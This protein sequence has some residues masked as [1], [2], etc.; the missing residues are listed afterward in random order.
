MVRFYAEMLP[1]TLER[2]VDECARIGGAERGEAGLLAWAQQH[3]KQTNWPGIAEKD[4]MSRGQCLARPP[5]SA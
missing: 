1:G 3:L 4:A 2:L 5:P